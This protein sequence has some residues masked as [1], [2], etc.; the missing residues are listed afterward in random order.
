MSSLPELFAIVLQFT[1]PSAIGAIYL[2]NTPV[3]YTSLAA[4][5]RSIVSTRRKW[6]ETGAPQ[7]PE[8]SCRKVEVIQ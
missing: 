2:G 6:E 7:L 5:R 8:V 3:V 1:S 4:C